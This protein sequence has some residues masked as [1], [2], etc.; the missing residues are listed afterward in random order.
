MLI[1]EFPHIDA[2]LMNVEPEPSMMTVPFFHGGEHH[3]RKR[4][5]GHSARPTLHVATGR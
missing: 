2:F 5:N 3:R 1:V 4:T